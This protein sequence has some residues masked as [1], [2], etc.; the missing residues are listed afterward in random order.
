MPLDDTLAIRASAFYR[1][2]PGY[3]DDV[4]TGQTHVDQAWADGGFFKALWQP[5]QT[6]LTQSD[7]T[8]AGLVVKWN[9]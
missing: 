6:V 9:I 3:I 5:S 2:D 4:L 1:T 7:R 8:C